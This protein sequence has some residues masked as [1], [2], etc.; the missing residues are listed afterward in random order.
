MAPVPEPDPI[1]VDGATMERARQLLGA[2]A[3]GTFDR[4]ELIPE[5]DAFVQ[6]DAFAKAPALLDTLGTPQSMYAFE[7][8]ITAD[9]TSTYF[10]VRYPEQILT[11]VVSV[12]ADS[13]ITGLCL[14]RSL[15]SS[16][17]C[18]V[19]REVHY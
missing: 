1:E 18:V 6:A 13:R 14:R 2:V 8:R 7:K 10:R 4:S 15:T 19:Y 9:Q 11:W 16:I 5:L 3:A 12:D 17:F